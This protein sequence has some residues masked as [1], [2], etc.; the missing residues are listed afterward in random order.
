MIEILYNLKYLK[1]LINEDQLLPN[2]FFKDLSSFRSLKNNKIKLKKSVL[3]LCDD[4]NIEDIKKIVKHKIENLHVV[5]ILNSYI[6]LNKI[7]EYFEEL[8]LLVKKNN[9][10][11]FYELKN[12]DSINFE[13]ITKKFV[14][15]NI[16]RINLQLYNSETNIKDLP[17]VLVQKLLENFYFDDIYILFFNP[18]DENIKCF[19]KSC[20]RNLKDIFRKKILFFKAKKEF[21]YVEVFSKLE[22][23]K[24]VFVFYFTYDPEY[25]PIFS[26]I[27]FKFDSKID[28]NIIRCITNKL[29][30][31]IDFI[32]YKLYLNYRLERSIKEIKTI[33]DVSLFFGLTS[34]V[35]ELIELVV[36]KAKN[37]FKADV[38][39]LMLIEGD[40]LYIKY[41]VGLPENIRNVRQKLGQ[42]IAG[43]VAITG[44][45]MIINDI[46]KI[47]ES[48]DL[49]KSYKVS[50][51]VPLKLRN[52]K[53]IGVLSVSKVSF[54]PFS[55]TD[56]QTLFNLANV[57][58]IAIEKS[59][60]YE[61]LNIYSE[62]LEESYINTIKSL[63]KA[64]EAKDKYNKG[65]MER[66]LKYGLAIASELDNSLLNDDVLKLALLF[67]DIGKIEIP[68]FILN[69]PSKLTAEEFEVIK[70]HPEAGE[71]ILKNVRFL[72]EVAQIV[73][74]HQER[75]DGKGYPLGLKGEGIHLYARIVALADAFDAMTSDRVYRKAMSL[76]EA[77]EEI[78]RNKG[79]QFDPMVVDAFLTAVDNGLINIEEEINEDLSQL[80]NIKNLKERV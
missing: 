38:C 66:V 33:H 46:D 77:I 49:E 11:I 32:S 15:S 58:A 43:K 13:E 40:E 23:F 53:I 64:F 71:E 20:S 2:S 52:D 70:R 51:V 10:Q 61:N 31:V 28:E 30:Q 18:F 25:N 65:H 7:H 56:L 4:F 22:D 26:S 69:K 48:T 75:W 19:P 44:K 17:N 57:A 14:D 24:E 21:D 76:E 29:K 68:D 74:Q 67:H 55:N 60:I 8:Q 16:N 72:Q 45:S 79:T 59:Q 63:A 37:I 34:S 42:G 62:K 36:K 3:F 12:V 47:K 5:I 41:S 9:I 27:F 50:M 80:I 39:T 54:Y 73:K 78:R 6:N 1:K 35:D